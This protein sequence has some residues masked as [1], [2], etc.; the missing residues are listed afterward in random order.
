MCT[1]LKIVMVFV[2][3][4]MTQLSVA[5]SEIN[6]PAPDFTLKS[7][8]GGQS[9][10]NLKLSEFRGQVVLLNFWASWCGPCR[11]EMPI[12]NDVYEKYK[13]LGVVVLGVNVESDPSLGQTFLKKTPVTFPVL[14][15][16]DNSVSEAYGVD[17]M[18]TTILIDRDGVIQQ[19]HK[20]YKD[21]YGDM[22]DK[23]V[24]KLIR[25]Q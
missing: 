10:E 9:G 22:Y 13:D 25:A 15:D 1:F 21:G 24:K 3:M 2:A 14:L 20:G 11:E 23:E 12:L 4:S 7:L 19:R 8:G 5:S 6:A 16:T 17:A 18:P